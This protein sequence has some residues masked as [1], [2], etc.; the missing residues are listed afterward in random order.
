MYIENYNVYFVY[1]L[2]ILLFFIRNQVEKGNNALYV[3]D[4]GI[5]DKISNN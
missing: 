5:S 4:V 3:E 2:C 1:A